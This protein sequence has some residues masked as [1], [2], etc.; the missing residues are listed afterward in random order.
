MVEPGEGAIEGAIEGDVVG[1]VV[2]AIEG[3]VEGA[4]VGAAVAATSTWYVCTVNQN[5]VSVSAS[6]RSGESVKPRRAP[7]PWRGR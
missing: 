2:G 4:E 7:R 1:D 5:M 6:L 3:D